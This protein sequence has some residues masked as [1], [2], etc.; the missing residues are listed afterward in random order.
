[1][2]YVDGIFRIGAKEGRDG[3]HIRFFRC[4]LLFDLIPICTK[5]GVSF[6]KGEG[7]ISILAIIGCQFRKGMVCNSPWFPVAPE[8]H[9]RD[10]TDIPDLCG[11]IEK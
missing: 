9:H 10:I 2:G 3:N 11:D 1:M 8:I 4:D 6:E 7:R 5:P